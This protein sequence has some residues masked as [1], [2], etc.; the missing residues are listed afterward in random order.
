MEVIERCGCTPSCY[1]ASLLEYVHDYTVSPVSS[2]EEEGNDDD[3]E[4]L[5]ESLDHQPLIKVTPVSNSFRRA[6][7]QMVPLVN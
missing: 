4:E 5:E 2:Q 3:D 7:H 1:R 6:F